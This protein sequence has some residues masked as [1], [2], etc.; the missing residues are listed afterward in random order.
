MRVNPK[1]ESFVKKNGATI[2]T[3]TSAAGVVSTAVLTSKATTKANR[4]L[5]EISKEKD[6]DLTLKEKVKYTVPIYI[7]AILVGTGTVACIFGANILNK[8]QQASLMSAYTL[9]DRSYKEYRNKVEE[10]YGEEVIQ[11][12][13][14]AI[15]KD[16]YP[17]RR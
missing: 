7:P 1:L 10:L 4:L 17:R 8:H 11:T 5:E 14:D 12:I 15:E 13:E 9:L 3:W 2:L 6:T 16:H